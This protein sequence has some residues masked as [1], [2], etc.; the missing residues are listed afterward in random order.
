MLNTVPFL[1]LAKRKINMA[2]LLLVEDDRDLAKGQVS[3]LAQS[4]DATD[5]VHSGRAALA[6]C[7]KAP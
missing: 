1:N 4:D 3:S 7:K 6:K 2:S 5:V